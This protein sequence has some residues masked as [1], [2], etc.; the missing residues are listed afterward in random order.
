MNS[1]GDTKYRAYIAETKDELKP[2]LQAG[3]EFIEWGKYINRNSRVFVKPNFTFPY[4]TEGVTTGPEFLKCLLELLKSKTDRVIVGESDG[5]NKSFTAEEAFQ[6]HN[7][8]QI[9]EQTGVEPVNLSKLPAETIE[10]HILGKKVNIQLP[11]LLLEGI[12]CFITVPVLK[13]HV[14]TTVTLSL[15]NSWGCV[16]DTMRCLQHQNLDYKLSLIASQLKPRIV[17]V[18]GTY[19]LNRHG[20]MYGEATETN[21]VLVADNTVAADALGARVMGF[22]PAQVRHIA[23]AEKSGLGSTDIADLEINQDWQKFQKQFHLK[24]TLIDQASTLLFRSDTL[25]RLVM[26]SPLT[27]VI[28][29][30]ASMLRSDEE[31]EVASQLGKVKTLGLY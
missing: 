21:L 16:P 3:L 7:L 4:Y 14:M 25:A 26:N 23:I 2:V 24:K 28:Y 9:C 13:V 8:Y 31:K 5:G 29:K 11:R 10:G 30:I 19:A 1:K 18:D 17:V 6:G 22:T 20:P 12:D 27:P 15:K